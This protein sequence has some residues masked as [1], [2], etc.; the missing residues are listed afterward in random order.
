MY[1]N[2]LD[3]GKIK[4][5]TDGASKGNLGEGSYGFCIRDNKGDLIY[6]QPKGVGIVTNI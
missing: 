4:C 6:A 2:F 5:N 1:W 3:A